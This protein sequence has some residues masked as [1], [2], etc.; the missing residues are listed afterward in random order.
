MPG[1]QRGSGCTADPL[2][3]RDRVFHVPRCVAGWA[4]G[5]ATIGL[6]NSRY[7]DKRMPV[8]TGVVR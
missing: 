3:S 1:L 6:R 8:V 2:P 5:V 7:A 4:W